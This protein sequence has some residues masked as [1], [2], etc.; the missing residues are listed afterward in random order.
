[1][2]A[3][4]ESATGAGTNLI[5]VRMLGQARALGKVAQE[6]VI[7]GRANV[8]VVDEAE[9][10]QAAREGWGSECSGVIKYHPLWFRVTFVEFGIYCAIGGVYL[11][12]GRPSLN[13]MRTRRVLKILKC[14]TT[15]S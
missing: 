12:L 10:V 8:A 1:M 4:E 5:K 7:E 14:S 15:T 13:L 9:R 2:Q 11:V 3:F 6:G